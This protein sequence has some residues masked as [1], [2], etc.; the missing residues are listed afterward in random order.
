MTNIV[1]FTPK[2]IGDGIAVNVED[3]LDNM[4]HCQRVFV[5]GV[6]KDGNLDMA[7]SHGNADACFLLVR[8]MS[9]L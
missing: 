2:I 6:D 7:S 5:V 1:S 9:N 8:A 4:K 3:V